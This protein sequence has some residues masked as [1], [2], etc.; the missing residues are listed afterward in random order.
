MTYF[1]LVGIFLMLHF[2]SSILMAQNE[3]V[4]WIFSFHTQPPPSGIPGTS[5]HFS[6]EP[7]FKTDTFSISSRGSCANISD[8]H[9]KMLFFTN[10]INIFNRDGSIMLNG[11]YINPGF[12]NDG[13]KNS[14]Y[15]TLQ[16]LVFLPSP[17]DSNSYHLIHVGIGDS[18]QYGATG[19]MFYYSVVRRNLP[20][21]T[22]YVS[23]KNQA[24]LADTLGMGYIT[25]T[26]HANGRDWWLVMPRIASNK[27]R[28]YLLDP[29]G[30]S[31]QNEQNIGY[32]TD[33][34]DWSGQ[35]VFSPDG[36]KFI[37]Y[38][39]FNKLN[40]FDFD[41]CTGKLSNPLHLAHPFASQ[42]S[43]LDGG[44]SV[45]P[46]S[47]YLYLS[48]VAWVYQYDLLAADIAASRTIVGEYD[49]TL[50][51]LPTTFFRAQLAPDGKIYINASAS[52]RSLHV[53]N[54]PDLP[55]LACGFQNNAV[56]V[57]NYI[58][59]GA[60]PYFPN[61]RLG[62][63]EGSGCDTLNGGAP[64][65]ASFEWQLVD[66]LQPLTA[67]FTDRSENAVTWV[68]DFGD[69]TTSQD[70]CPVHQ[71][72]QAGTYQACLKVGNGFG[73]DSVCHQV[74]LQHTTVQSPSNRCQLTI[75]PNPSKDEVYFFCQSMA[76]RK[77]TL[78][79]VNTL[80][81]PV[82]STVLKGTSTK[83]DVG[84]FQPGLYYAILLDEG[85][86]VSVR[87]FVVGE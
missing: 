29:N 53:I 40:I 66:T 82:H 45:S 23:K 26:K 84:S 16:G 62:A 72:A 2:G 44:V 81:Q 14:G 3:D 27:Y 75:Y 79:I 34:R 19:M 83:V 71:Y 43:L 50:L 9:G 74:H 28:V 87:P 54:N 21:S 17:G 56:I 5:V 73:T 25:A 77:A 59:W 13:Y 31:L 80:Q 32:V 33:W 51:P 15:P 55:G 65:V 20:D 49:G 6:P 41:R 70:S 12:I 69:G 68:W 47:R 85:A 64:P 35:S 67:K 42:D 22:F 24:I 10:G 18:G 38:S 48:A 37:R 63:L 36:S 11:D 76:S 86:W 4:N 78:V 30:V 60:M 1:R 58:F 39:R 57:D 52:N 7:T 8:K 46:N 61:Y